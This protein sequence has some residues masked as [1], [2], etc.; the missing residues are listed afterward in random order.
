M[1]QHIYGSNVWRSNDVGRVE[2]MLKALVLQGDRADSPEEVLAPMDIDAPLAAEMSCEKKSANVSAFNLPDINMLIDGSETETANNTSLSEST[3]IDQLAGVCVGDTRLELSQ[4][5]TTSS[6]SRPSRATTTNSTFRE[7]IR[8]ERPWTHAEMKAHRVSFLSNRLIGHE[9]ISTFAGNCEKTLPDWIALLRNATLPNGITSEDPRIIA[10]FKAV[11]SVICGQGSKMLRRLANVHLMRL[12]GSL[13]AIIETDRE[14][15]RIHREPYYRD[16]HVA[17]DIYI[18]AQETHSNT[19]ELRLMLRR[20]RKRFSKR[21]SDLATASP[22]FV[23][24]YSD[25]AESIVYVPL[26][27]RCF[28]C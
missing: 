24:V 7:M 5:R 25:A 14:T 13:E 22:L 11:D 10:A 1:A 4:A 2:E 16:D 8:E 18:S 12:F 26:P 9:P 17:M 20:G 15:G 21:W 27:V 3:N 6:N 23:L 28:I 19:N